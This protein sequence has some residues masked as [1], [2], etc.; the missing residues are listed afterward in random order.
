MTLLI[1]GMESTNSQCSEYHAGRLP[2][3]SAYINKFGEFEFIYVE[4]CVGNELKDFFVEP[5][6]FSFSF[7]QWITFR[8]EQNK[9]A[10]TI[11][12]N[13]ATITVA[14]V[15]QTFAYNDVSVWIA[16]DLWSNLYDWPTADATVR[17]IGLCDT[18][19]QQIQ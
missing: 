4:I 19:I 15:A 2:T 6:Q 8:I 5:E 18:S 10:T 11:S 16:S 9:S 17:H 13:E 3:L 14:D 1:V 7:G 12:I